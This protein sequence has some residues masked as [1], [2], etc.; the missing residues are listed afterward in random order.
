M[1]TNILFLYGGASFEHEVSCL[2][3]KNIIKEINKEKYNYQIIYISKNILLFRKEVRN[4]WLIY[5]VLME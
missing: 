4:S 1:K 2:S 5:S 3:I